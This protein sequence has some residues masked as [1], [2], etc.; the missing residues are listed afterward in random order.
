MHRLFRCH[1]NPSTL[2]LLAL[3]IGAIAHAQTTDGAYPYLGAGIGQA[4]SRLDAA[5]LSAAALSGSELTIT[6]TSSDQRDTAYKLFGGL[7]FNRYLGVELGYFRLG[8]F[9][10][11][12]I[13]SP[14]GQLDGRLKVA[15]MNLDLVGSLPFSEDLS[16]LVRVGYQRAR[17]SADWSGSG[18][19]AG[20]S[21]SARTND[22]APRYG[23]GLQYAVTPQ[24]LMRADAERSRF[25]DAQGSTVRATAYT[26][27]AIMPFGAP[28]Q[29]ARRAAY[30]APE[31]PRAETAPMPVAVVAPPPVL[32]A[33]APAPLRRVSFTAESLFGFD[34]A[35]LR[36]PGKAAL[37][38][39]ASELAGM[40]FDSIAVTGHADRLGSAAYNQALSSKRADAVKAYLVGSANVDTARISAQGHG[41]SEPVTHPGDCKG[42]GSPRVIACLQPDR[43][44]DIQVSGTR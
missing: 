30:V 32:P 33:P 3:F 6:S 26:V 25:A 40:R 36:P 28:P 13:T 7:Q 29:P 22:S 39:F 16:G 27:S 17:T 35:V 1:P 24:L 8:Q 10:Y 21:R 14:A 41:E 15:G 18:A 31:P 5:R 11:R 43:R 9:S 19:V 2:A 12:A 34:S 44:V 23:V 38:V 4:R 37:D 42:A 20:A